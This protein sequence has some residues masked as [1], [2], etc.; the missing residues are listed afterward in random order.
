MPANEEFNIAV[1]IVRLSFRPS[2]RDKVDNSTEWYET[3]NMIT[4]E[5]N[6]R[7][8]ARG[9][10]VD[11]I[12]DFMIMVGWVD[13]TKP[14]AA[15]LPGSPDLDTIFAPLQPLL[16]QRPRVQTLRHDRSEATP[17]LLTTAF[18][19]TLW[20]PMMEILTVRGPA[21]LVEQGVKAVNDTIWRYFQ[22]R[23]AARYDDEATDDYLFNGLTMVSLD[24]N[25]SH[26]S[27]GGPDEVASFALIL[28]W[29]NREGRAD[30]QDPT[31][32]D[33]T[34]TPAMRP[35]YPGSFWQQRVAKPLQILV[36]QGATVS[37]WDYHKTEIA[38]DEKGLPIVGKGEMVW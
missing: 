29:S 27:S 35:R 3:M 19:G 4:K 36:E 21:G 12:C 31:L 8:V 16:S 17:N 26:D 37:S 13:G 32:P 6:F 7:Y 24:D 20:E 1:S 33:L 11:D 9:E 25:S 14:S 15:F 22:F 23:Q 2:D 34:L 5:P 10:G 38:K 30:F 18:R 28:K